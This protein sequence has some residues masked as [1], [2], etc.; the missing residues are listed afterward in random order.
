MCVLYDLTHPSSI[1]ADRGLDKVKLKHP[2]A[3]VGFS[4]NTV[5]LACLARESPSTFRRGRIT[6]GFPIALAST[7]IIHACLLDST[8]HRSSSLPSFYFL[9]FPPLDYS[10]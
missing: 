9:S 3:I 10:G 6:N 8:C 1:L 7:S 2:G 5:S 4:I